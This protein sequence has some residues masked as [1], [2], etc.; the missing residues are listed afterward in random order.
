M[1]N[2]KKK[3]IAVLLTA[4]LLLV[5]FTG[6]GVEDAAEAITDIIEEKTEKT[7][8]TE[9]IENTAAETSS[10]GVKTGYVEIPEGT[11]VI[12]FDGDLEAFR[13]EIAEALANRE[14]TICV[15]DWI[16]LQT[17]DYYTLPYSTF[18]LKDYS[19]NGVI[20]KTETDE[21]S[22]TYHFYEYHYYDLT[23]EEIEQMKNEIDAAADQIISMVPAGADDWTCAKVVHDEL[24]KLVTY[25]QS[26]EKPHTHDTYGALVNHEA[27]CSGYACAF[28][29]IMS[30]LGY[31]SPLSYSDVHAWNNLA[32]VSDEQYI[33]ITWD[34]KDIV[35][36]YG[37][38]YIDY[39]FFFLTRAEVESVESHAIQS[40]DPYSN[41]PNSLP[42]NY[43]SHE[44]Y[45]VDSYDWNTIAEM[46][47]RQFESGSNLLTIRFTNDEDY[48][49]ALQ[50]AETGFEELSAL[51]TQW[52]YYEPYYYWSN[53]DMK[54]YSI[55]LY[56]AGETEEAETM[57]A[58]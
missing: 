4:C 5:S 57:E 37:R 41:T 15:Q 8:E 44:G 7:E 20:G 21:R 6:C 14:T 34:D 36:A 18:W 55:G 11:R 26:L 16:W 10:S 25:D 35:D 17:V 38:E 39:S 9:N 1:K 27:V 3:G 22:H 32:V 54:T 48:Q 28:S 45:L 40:G 50:W 51:M 12:A 42:Y 46:F 58:G 49:Q 53:D 56:A 47:T 43:Y 29:Y 19:A 52:D 33:D 13:G 2:M 30:R 31:Y 23:D 24:C